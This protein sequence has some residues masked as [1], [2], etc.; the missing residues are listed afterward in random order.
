MKII[1]ST[2]ENNLVSTQNK[3]LVGSF[4]LARGLLLIVDRKLDGLKGYAFNEGYNLFFSACPAP[5]PLYLLRE[6]LNL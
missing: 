4:L 3:P 6:V 1:L 2:H 5:V